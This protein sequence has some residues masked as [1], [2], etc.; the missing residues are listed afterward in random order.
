MPGAR[1]YLNALPRFDDDLILLRHV[2]LP[3]VRHLPQTT[4]ACLWIQRHCFDIQVFYV[5]S[6]AAT[7]KDAH[8][9]V[10]GRTIKEHLNRLK[11]TKGRPHA[12]V[13]CDATAPCLMNSRGGFGMIHDS[14]N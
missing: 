5:V 2:E 3:Y 7:L 4:F 13:R 11:P 10:C 12:S 8:T 14:R 1:L 9:P 6:S